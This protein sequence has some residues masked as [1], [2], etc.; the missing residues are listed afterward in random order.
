[1]S[2]PSRYPVSAFCTCFRKASARSFLSGILVPWAQ[3]FVRF[4]DS[5]SFC[6]KL[7]FSGWII[8]SVLVFASTIPLCKTETSSG[9]SV[10]TGRECLVL[11]STCGFLLI[12]G[13]TGADFGS[14]GDKWLPSLKLLNRDHEFR[15]LSLEAVRSMPFCLAP[16]I[17]GKCAFFV[18]TTQLWG[19]SNV[20]PFP[21]GWDVNKGLILKRFLKSS[22][23]FWKDEGHG[24]CI[25][26]LLPFGKPLG[27]FWL[28]A[29]SPNFS[30]ELLIS[31]IS[32]EAPGR[33][34][35]CR[36]LLRTV[37]IS[38]I[39]AVMLL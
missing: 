11:R 30:K 28:G 15:F 9:S 6:C 3:S 37:S 4:T 20:P 38:S 31:M 34:V 8:W 23:A 32:V 35:I 12:S 1:M 26:C 19:T 27:S 33:E 24:T 17:T 14:R 13:S 39:M 36:L 18:S 25:E 16:F 29:L 5:L 22:G 10:V 21:G 7:W 2:M